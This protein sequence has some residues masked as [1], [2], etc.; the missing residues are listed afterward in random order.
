MAIR[1]QK[2]NDLCHQPSMIQAD[3]PTSHP[4]ICNSVSRRSKFN[5]LYLCNI[6]AIQEKNADG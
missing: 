6:S 2:K 5:G 3:T 1:K 4:I